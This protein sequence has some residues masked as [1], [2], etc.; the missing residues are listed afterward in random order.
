M[1][2]TARGP[3]SFGYIL[4]CDPDLKPVIGDAATFAREPDGSMI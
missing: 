3:K 2:D 1:V 4:S